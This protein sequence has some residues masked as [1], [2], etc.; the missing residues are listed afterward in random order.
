[1][2]IV[3]AI[4]IASILIVLGLVGCILPILPGPPLS[5]IGLIIMA[6]VRDFSPP[7]TISVL[8]VLG[9]LALIAAVLD[10]II[11]AIGAKRYGAS[12][13]GVTGSILG[14]FI[15][16]FFFPPLGIL[17]GSFLG[18][19]LFELFSGKDRRAAFRAGKGV[20]IG[21]FLAFTFKLMVSG[22]ITYYFVVALF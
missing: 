15:G 9:F 22:V 13:W 4:I 21:S 18:A 11:P 16:I 1:M 5:F 8:I 19:F 3:F 10:Y 6:F 7:I 14:M 2:L 12:R 20:L 17:I